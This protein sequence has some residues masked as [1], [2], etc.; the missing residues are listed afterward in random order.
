MH[1]LQNKRNNYEISSKEFH[2][3]YLLLHQLDELN[4]AYEATKD[5]VSNILYTTSQYDSCYSMLT[6][7]QPLFMY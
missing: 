6:H 1:L 7:T 4:T 2:E 3:Y 5:L